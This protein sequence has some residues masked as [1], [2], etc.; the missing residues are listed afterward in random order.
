MYVKQISKLIMSTKELRYNYKKNLFEKF[1]ILSSSLLD[2]GVIFFCI[3]INIVRENGCMALPV[4]DNN[5]ARTYISRF[6]NS[7]CG[8]YYTDCSFGSVEIGKDDIPHIYFVVGFRIPEDIVPFI[9]QKIESCLYECYMLDYKI[10]YLPE[11]IDVR[12]SLRYLS[13]DFNKECPLDV[14]FFCTNN[15]DEDITDVFEDCGTISRLSDDAHVY[16]FG[17]YFHKESIQYEGFHSFLKLCDL[18]SSS[19]K[20]KNKEIIVIVDYLNFFFA[21]HNIFIFKGSL[22][23]K[24]DVSLNSYRYLGPS[25][26]VKSHFIQFMNDLNEN[27]LECFDVS[28]LSLTFFNNSDEIIETLSSACSNTN[29]TLNL[30][31][32]EFKDGLYLAY[33]DTFIDRSNKIEIDSLSKKFFFIRHYSYYYK[34]Y[35]CEKELAY[36]LF[37]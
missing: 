17:E 20:D 5:T 21:L 16:F 9:R 2:A 11:F 35:L 22:Y 10:S 8:I 18:F 24:I 23:Q 12:E 33:N 4:Y 1:D 27:T 36:K 28:A 19:L 34:T 37:L 14:C 6:L 32:L 13:K 3:T 31:V 25:E 26:I 15:Y 30:D 7:L 29:K